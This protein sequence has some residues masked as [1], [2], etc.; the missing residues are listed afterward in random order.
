MSLDLGKCISEAAPV[1]EGGLGQ[2]G[3][4]AKLPDRLAAPPGT[5]GGFS[6]T[7]RAVLDQQLVE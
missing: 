2:A 6:V 4:I 7:P 5:G 3:K 1:G